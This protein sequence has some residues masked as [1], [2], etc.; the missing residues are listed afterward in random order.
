MQRIATK[1]SLLT[2]Q[3]RKGGRANLECSKL[4][5]GI[6][7]TASHST[8]G[9]ISSTPRRKKGCGRSACFIHG[10]AKEALGSNVACILSRVFELK[11]SSYSSTALHCIPQHHHGSSPRASSKFFAPTLHS[12]FVTGT[13]LSRSRCKYRDGYSRHCIA[14]HDW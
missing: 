4:K 10:G 6:L 1:V 8:T 14:L 5:M 2:L 12:L 11:T 7:V 13:S 9:D 3:P